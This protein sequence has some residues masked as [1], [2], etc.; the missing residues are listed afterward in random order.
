MNIYQPPGL[1]MD[2]SF[3]PFREKYTCIQ[4]SCLTWLAFINLITASDMYDQDG[5]SFEFSEQ[6]SSSNA[7][8]S[9]S[10]CGEKRDYCNTTLSIRLLYI[11]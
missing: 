1:K 2:C 10:L 3:I 9:L 11:Q 6:L 8:I 4:Q 7:V 5:T